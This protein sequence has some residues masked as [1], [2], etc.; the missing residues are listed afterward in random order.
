MA[1]TWGRGAGSVNDSLP[2]KG[3]LYILD[4][5]MIFTSFGTQKDLAIYACCV[6]GY[7]GATYAIVNIYIT[8]CA[9]QTQLVLD[10]LLGKETKSLVPGLQSLYFFAQ[11]TALEVTQDIS[12]LHVIACCMQSWAATSYH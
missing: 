1:G 6:H 7:V 12:R 3:T 9:L 2:K 5:F 8:G 4:H 11:L 10:M